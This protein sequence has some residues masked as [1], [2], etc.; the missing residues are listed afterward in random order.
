MNIVDYRNVKKVYIGTIKF[1]SKREAQRYQEL[2]LLEKAHVITDIKCHPEF[3]LIPTF[4]KFGKTYR[5]IKYVADFVYTD[6]EKD[7]IMIEDVKGFSSQLFLV[8]QKLFEY[9]Y[10]D[11]TITVIR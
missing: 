3:V 2:L 7:K 4:K 6:L 11:L 10:K 1:D 8:K 9:F 5:A